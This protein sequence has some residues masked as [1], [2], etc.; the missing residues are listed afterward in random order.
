MS[1]DLNPN[2][3]PANNEEKIHNVTTLG[4]LYENW[5][6]DYASY[7]ILDRAVPHL[8]D[9]LKP[10]QRRI[11]H[12][13]KEMDDGR[14]NKAANVIGNTMKYHPHGD[15][16]IG[17]AMVQIGQKNLLI[18]CQGNWGDP[19]TGDSAAA[20]RYIE[21]RLSKFAIEVVF[22]ADTTDWQASYDGRNREPITL[23]VKFPLLLAQGAEGIAVGLATKIL[24]HN[25]CELCD[26]A[27][28]YLK[29]KK[30]ELYP[31]FLTAGMIDITNYN[32][33]KR[34]GKVR[35]RTHIEE[36]DKKTLLVKDVPYGVT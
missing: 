27:I 22:N 28:K 3:T 16:S 15:A 23:P 31:D 33:G 19:V 13:L 10:V 21:A 29:G 17:D 1:E 35:V 26:A 7:V 24:P 34:G 30:F 9:G 11:L 20:P 36:M 4:G 18:D 5:F 8:H 6:L 2:D 25:F 14:F 32:D 12:S